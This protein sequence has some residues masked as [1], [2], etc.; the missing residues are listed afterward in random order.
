[1][2]LTRPSNHSSII[3]VLSYGPEISSL[4]WGAAQYVDRIL[5]GKKPSE[6][7]VQQP[8]RLQLVLNLK[9]AKDLGLAISPALQARH[10]Y[11]FL[12]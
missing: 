2:L 12:C 11:V 10:A 4:V 5:K 6:L 9:T 7:P 3:M 1:M 8:S